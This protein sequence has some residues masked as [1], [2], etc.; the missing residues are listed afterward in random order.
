M[1]TSFGSFFPPSKIWKQ[2][3]LHVPTRKLKLSGFGNTLKSHLETT[4]SGLIKKERQL[5]VEPQKSTGFFSHLLKHPHFMFLVAVG[6]AEVIATLM[7]TLHLVVFWMAR[8]LQNGLENHHVP[9]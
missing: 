3:S 5:I 4:F 9:D 1:L 6:F 8:C 7:S 2:F